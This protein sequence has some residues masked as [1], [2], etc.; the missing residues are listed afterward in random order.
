MV[1]PN[2]GTE[3]ACFTESNY[4]HL[5]RHVIT[6]CALKQTRRISGECEVGLYTNH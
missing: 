4:V 1:W 3:S 2:V 5:H 6:P